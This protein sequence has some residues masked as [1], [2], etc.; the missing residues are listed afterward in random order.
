M[1]NRISNIMSTSLI[2][3][4]TKSNMYEVAT[5]MSER[6]VSSIF[7]T[8]ED[9]K[10]IG[11]STYNNDNSRIVG[12]ITQTDLTREICAKDLQASKINAASIMSP[13]IMIDKDAKIGQAAEMMIRN[14]IRHLAVKEI[15]GKILGIVTGTDLARYLKEK[16]MRNKNASRYLRGE[17]AVVD[18]LSFPESL[19]TVTG[20]QDDQ[21]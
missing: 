12:I 16:L 20:N 11:D 15:S 19:P 7:L 1:T 2:T 9:K 5:K 4:S 18:A 8:D 13:L 17:L 3:I 10:T 6:K 21:C 14:G